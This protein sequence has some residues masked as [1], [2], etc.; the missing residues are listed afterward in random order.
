MQSWRLPLILTS[1]SL[2]VFGYILLFERHFIS[3]TQRAEVGKRLFPAFNPSS[4]HQITIRIRKTD[5][6]RLSLEKGRWLL[7]EPFNFAADHFAVEDLLWLLSEM[8]FIQKISVRRDS[9]L[10]RDYGLNDPRV[11]IRTK[12]DKKEEIELRIGSSSPRPGS[13][14]AQIRKNDGYVYVIPEEIFSMLSRP[15]DEWRNKLLINLADQQIKSIRLESN[16]V[17]YEFLHEQGIWKLI[18]PE[19]A[20]LDT[21]KVNSWLGSLLSARAARYGDNTVQDAARRLNLESI[22][23]LE[24]YNDENEIIAGLRLAEISIVDDQPIKVARRL[25]ENIWMCLDETT[26]SLILPQFDSLVDRRFLSIPI[27]SVSKI[28]L[29]S[30]EENLTISRSE[31]GWSIANFPYSVEHDAIENYLGELAKISLGKKIQPGY[32]DISQDVCTVS[33]WQKLESGKEIKA[34]EI[35]IR[36]A[37]DIGFYASIPGS[38]SAFSIDK[39]DLAKIL[40]KPGH[41][42][43]KKFTCPEI[44]QT[45][46]LTIEIANEQKKLTLT[47]RSDISKLSHLLRSIDVEEWTDIHICPDRSEINT[48]KISAKNS[49]NSHMRFHICTFQEKA[50]LFVFVSAD[51]NQSFRPTRAW[52]SLFEK[53]LYDFFKDH[54]SNADTL[55]SDKMPSFNDNQN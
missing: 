32:T 41:F 14:Y 29:S 45:R 4:A 22:T 50:C 37:A 48:I 25:G 23:S 5:D 38:Q 1:L 15:P 30:N 2:I 21:D 16:D 28:N 51:K 31:N 12:W 52:F 34:S 8:E 49:E 11:V 43:V 24:L 3:S 42:R 9:S 17:R 13:L 33:F 35:I 20:R 47:E 46:L 10:L 19:N 54:I 39:K 36:K 44:D 6:I 7:E 40:V 27:S 18:S 53:T 26:A 55:N